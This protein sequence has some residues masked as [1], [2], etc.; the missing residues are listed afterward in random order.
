MGQCF[1]PSY[2]CYRVQLVRIDKK[3]KKKTIV[4]FWNR[5]SFGSSELMNELFEVEVDD[6]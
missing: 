1:L 3:K 5:G 4:E 6:R 2:S